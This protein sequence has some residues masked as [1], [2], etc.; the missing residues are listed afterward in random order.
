MNFLLPSVGNKIGLACLL[1]RSVRDAGGRLLGSDID[2]KAPALAH[3][4]EILELPRFDDLG[5]WPALGEA[6]G[7][8]AV[9]AV[10][11][12]R[13][14]ELLG[15]AKAR[16]ASWLDLKILVS[17][18]RTVSVCTDKAAL[19]RLAESVR[20]PCPEWVLP[21]EVETGSRVRFPAVLKPRSGAGSRE[22]NIV[23]SQVE[24]EQLARGLRAGYLLQAMVEGPE[25]SVDCF[26]SADGE[27]SVCSPRERQ[28]VEHGQCIVG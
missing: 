1:G 19:Y 17:S 10:I 15:W 11:P 7:I 3:V 24:F 4:D 6:V 25:Y 2:P 5:F 23:G 13:N 18:S 16:E 9:H 28:V 20:V 26:A 14:E 22:V 27:L 12:V 21:D 8:G